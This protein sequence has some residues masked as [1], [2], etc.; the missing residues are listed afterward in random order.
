[1][2]I[3]DAKEFIKSVIDKKVKIAV[4]MHGTMGIGKSWIIE[5]IAEELNIPFIDLRLAQMEPGDLIGIPRSRDGQTVW[6]RPEW[7]PDGK[8][9]PE[10]ILFLDEL[11]RAPQDV[12]QAIFQLVNARRMMTHKLPAGWG[13]VSAVNPENSTMNYQVESLD[14]A[15]LRRFCNIKVTPD[16]EVWLKWAINHGKIDSAITGFIAAHGE[17]LSGK[18]DFKL[19][20]TA[21]P[22]Q[23]RMI[24]ELIKANIIPQKF[25]MEIF[26]GLVG[27]TAATALVKF[28]DANYNRPVSGNE[29]LNN[30]PKIRAKLKRQRNDENHVTVKEVAA[31]LDSKKPTKKL[32]DNLTQFIKDLPAE[33]QATIVHKLSKD[34]LTELMNYPELTK[35]I[36]AIMKAT[37]KDARG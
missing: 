6:D 19:E 14:P 18:D 13:I 27:V 9:Q 2:Y 33:P 31:E 28:I 24:D 10:G 34:Y 29:V 20:G 7:F 16:P 5:Q 26:R 8:E 15:M 22:D 36:A 35:E 12:R 1:M 21:A 23:Y 3:D 30:Y 32:M 11:N 25:Q 4:M 17:L 37:R